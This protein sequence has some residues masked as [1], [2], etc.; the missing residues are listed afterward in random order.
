MEI[1][2]ATTQTEIFGLIQVRKEVFIKEQNVPVYLEMDDEDASAMHLI[3][4]NDDF[5]IGTCRLIFE[6]DYIKL[7][8]LAVLKE[9]RYQG[10]ASELLNYAEVQAKL[11]NYSSIHLGAQVQAIDFYEKNGYYIISDIFLDADIPHKMMEK[12]IN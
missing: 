12:I 8:R 3:A 2:I 4:I 5:V 6:T 11:H 1:K 7:G 9:Y 10:I